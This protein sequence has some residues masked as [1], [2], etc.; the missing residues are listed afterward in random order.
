MPKDYIPIS[1][2]YHHLKVDVLPIIEILERLNYQKLIANYQKENAKS[3]KTI[4]HHKNSRNKV[5]ESVTCPRCGS[6][7][8]IYMIIHS[9]RS[10]SL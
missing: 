7:I 3:F 6:H 1:K 9:L 10:L 2:E 8:F 5:P 4:R